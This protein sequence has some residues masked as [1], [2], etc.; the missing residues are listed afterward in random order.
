MTRDPR[1]GKTRAVEVR[2]TVP[3]DAPELAAILVDIGWFSEGTADETELAARTAERVPPAEEAGQRAMPV[4]E[5]KGEIVGYAQPH[6]VP[7][8]FLAGPEAY[9]TELFVAGRARGHGVGGLLL[10]EAIRVAGGWGASRM[11]LLSHR[12]RESYQRGFYPA[13]G[14]DEAARLAVMRRS[15]A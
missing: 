6:R 1:S 12:G 13:R 11:S 3:E 4:A 5:L 7:M 15:L 8:L 9:L 10:D 2:A 14:F